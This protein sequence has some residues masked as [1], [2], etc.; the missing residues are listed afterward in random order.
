M[1]GCDMTIFLCILAGVVVIYGFAAINL[2]LGYQRL[3]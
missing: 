2:R 1:R 3:L